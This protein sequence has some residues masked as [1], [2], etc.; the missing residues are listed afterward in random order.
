[1][2]AIRILLE[3]S[4]LV[5]TQRKRAIG[6]RLKKRFVLAKIT[7]GIIFAYIRN[8]VC[9]KEGMG[10]DACAREN[11]ALMTSNNNYRLYSAVAN[12]QMNG[13]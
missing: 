10:R 2:K 5:L 11:D 7:G 13:Y 3:K 8:Y 4:T 12:L 9:A 6:L 1:M